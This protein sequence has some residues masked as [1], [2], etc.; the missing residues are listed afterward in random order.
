MKKHKNPQKG[1]TLVEIMIVVVI[2]GLLAAMAIPAFN[3]VRQT[4]QAKTCVNN[5]RQISSAKDQ[6]FIENGGEDSVDLDDLVGVENYIKATP[7]CPAGGEYDEE[8]TPDAE[9]ECSEGGDHVLPSG[10]VEATGG[11]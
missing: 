6:Y 1:F 9:P 5:L 11:N 3:K 7:V 10:T 8:L 2:I 4:S